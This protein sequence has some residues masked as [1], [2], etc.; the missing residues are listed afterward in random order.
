MPSE[1]AKKSLRGAVA[2]A[3]A[4]SAWAVQQPL[5]KRVFGCDYDDVELLGKLATR[6]DAWLPA[7]VALHLLNGAIF[8]AA[9]ANVAPLIPLPAPARGPAAGLAE[10]VG[11]W[12]MG[13]ISDRFHPARGEMPQLTGNTRAFAQATWRHLLFGVVLGELE[14]RLNPPEPEPPVF[15]TYASTNGHGS[16]EQVAAVQSAP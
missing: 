3:I 8:G 10:H 2:G 9:Y 1:R 5:D 6:S 11:L 12:P 14:R 15:E 13:R 4:A 16:L 7:G